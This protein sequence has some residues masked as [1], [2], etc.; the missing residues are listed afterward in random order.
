MAILLLAAFALIGVYW[1]NFTFI[2]H[3]LSAWSAT[4][5]FVIALL[6]LRMRATN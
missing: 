4:L 5:Y 6:F 1:Q 2:L 3:V